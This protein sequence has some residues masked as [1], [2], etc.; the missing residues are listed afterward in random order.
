MLQDLSSEDK[1]AKAS[2]NNVAYAFN[3]I[4]TAR[5]LEE[6]KSTAGGVTVNIELTYQ[7]ATKASRELRM[8]HAGSGKLVDSDPEPDWP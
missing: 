7:E 4:H 2:L 8:K 1:R 3:Q 5:R 6:G